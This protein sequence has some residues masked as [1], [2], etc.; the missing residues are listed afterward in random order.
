MGVVKKQGITNTIIVYV[1]IAIGFVSLLVI[2][3]QLLNPSEVGLIRIL[4]SVS[5]LLAA[6][7]P[8]GAPNIN[9]KYLPKFY[10][11]EKNHH[12]FFGLMLIFP[13]V[14]ILIGSGLLFL[15]KDWF[16]GLYIE[17]SPLFVSYFSYVLPLAIF[18][19]FIY[20]FNSYCNA[21][22]KTIFPSILNDVINRLLLILI[23][24]LYFLSIIDLD[25][26]VLSFVLI[27][28]IQGIFLLIYIFYVGKISLR[29]DLNYTEEK[30]GIKSIIRYGLILTFTS[31]SSISIK[32]L[33]S[34][35]LGKQSLEAVGI[36]SVAAF[37][38]LI[39][40]TPLN[41]LERIANSKIAHLLSENNLEEVEKIYKTSSRY[42]MLL[43]A[44]LTCMVVINIQ[45][46]LTLLPKAYQ[47]GAIVTIIVSIGAFINMATGINY[48]IL[49]NSSKYIWGSF[50]LLILL[51]TSLFG[52]W[53]LIEKFQWGIMGAAIATTFSSSIYNGLKFF[54]IWKNFKMQPFTM[55]SIKIILI[56]SICL[57]IGLVIPSTSTAALSIFI[58]AS[59]C[60]LLF[61]LLTWYFNI[62]P[63]FHK[64]LLWNRDNSE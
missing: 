30:V 36:Y 50:F 11:P 22:F 42:L 39:I 10:S 3:P 56:F 6:V 16:V 2:Q 59:I 41:S 21:I 25:Q 40:E 58:R 57:L 15:C 18:I 23:I 64:Y 62:V 12:G 49:I 7:F 26:F 27:Y 35:F 1:G 43:G 5:S 4:L 14:G 19:T 34:V 8:L 46:L 31:V 48:P 45:D 9:V 37:I 32:Y 52:N 53:L 61:V 17:K 33:D 29:P 44:F 20:S 63:E 55:I 38:A 60:T 47:S 51:L 13:V 24:V 28:A 54:F